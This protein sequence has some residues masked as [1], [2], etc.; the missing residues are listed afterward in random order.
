[1]EENIELIKNEFNRIKQ[2]GYVKAV[3]NNYS[4]IGLTFEKLLGK[5]ADDFSLPDFYNIEIKSKL[6]YS[7][8]PINLFRLTP[9]GKDFFEIKRIYDTYG[10][11]RKNYGNYKVF[12]AKA[13]AHELRKWYD[14]YYS[15]K[16][17]Y[18]EKKL[19]LLIYDKNIELIDDYVYWN[20]EKLEETLVRK[21]SYLAIV[22]AFDTSRNGEKYYK[23]YNISIYKFKGFDYFLK[24]L[25]E[26]K[27]TIGFSIDIHKF[28]KMYGQ[29]HDHGTNFSVD[30]KYINDI[31]DLV[32]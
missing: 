8:S 32:E 9:E 16:V 1:M 20:F 26:G 24:L 29:M 27:I 3:N 12:F 18:N 11:C 5:E 15:L 25:D 30:I 21:L 19:R 31:F 23:Y 17:D 13:N 7:K 6:A 22:K 4:G 14:N 28:E 2:L 10:C